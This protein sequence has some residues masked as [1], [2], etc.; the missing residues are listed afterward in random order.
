MLHRIVIGTF[1]I[2]VS[3]LVFACSRDSMNSPVSP[4]PVHGLSVEDV[5]TSASAGETQGA[6]RHGPAPSPSGGPRITASGN[7]TVVNGGTLVV[8]LSADSPFGAIYMFVGSKTVG[9]T[10]EASGGIEGHYEIR[11]PSL[12][13]SAT[14]LLTF[15]QDIPLSEFE[16]LFAVANPSGAVGS[17]TGLSTA[18]TEVGTGDVQVTLAWDVDSDVDL[19]VVGPGGEEI[20]YGRPRSASG[21]ALDLD[22]N[23]GCSIDGIRNEN[24]TWPT[25]RAPSG[26]YT[27]RVD[28]WSSCGVSRT[29][30]TVRINNGGNTQILT[31]SLTG[32]GDQGGLGSGRSL[33]TFDRS[34]GPAVIGVSQ[35]L[36]FGPAPGILTKG[37]TAGR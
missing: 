36:R 31:G 7:R 22:S 17:F 16:L 12:E 6:R 35:A 30:F 21:G 32:L 11:L 25:G 24:I 13:T 8:T 19:H 26:Q 33:A 2:A 18:V 3:S 37:T 5:A 29:N 10:G 15:P 4:S 23:A 20:F 1:V 9:L 28:Y 27:V 34:T 14:V